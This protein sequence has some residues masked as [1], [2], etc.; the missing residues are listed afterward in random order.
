MGWLWGPRNSGGNGKGEEVI[1][2]WGGVVKRWRFK[3]GWEGGWQQG[4]QKD[5]EGGEYRRG[6]WWRWW[7]G[8]GVW[9]LVGI[10]EIPALLLQLVRIW[11]LGSFPNK[12]LNQ[13]EACTNFSNGKVATGLL[14]RKESESELCCNLT[15]S[16]CHSWVYCGQSRRKC[17]TD[18]TVMP[19]QWGHEGTP[20][21]GCGRGAGSD[22]CD[23]TWARISA[24]KSGSVP[25]FCLNWLQLGPNQLFYF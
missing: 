11:S 10:G 9:W 18:S 7:G 4:Q 25:V 3:V 12:T 21:C 22:Q 5:V 2:F 8:G 24:W 20:L 17:L 6:W 13:P 15:L 19:W 14:S 1:M 16:L 23:L